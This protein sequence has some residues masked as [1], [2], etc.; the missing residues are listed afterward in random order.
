MAKGGPIDEDE[1]SL[2]GAK[3]IRWLMKINEIV[4]NIV[5]LNTEH[6]SQIG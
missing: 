5:K 4:E 2:E 6:R 1:V 3:G